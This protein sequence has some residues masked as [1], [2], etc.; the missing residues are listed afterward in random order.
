MKN[1]FQMP[2]IWKKVNIIKEVIRLN[3]VFKIHF[4]CSVHPNYAEVLNVIC[5]RKPLS[6]FNIL[7]RQNLNRFI[8][9]QFYALTNLIT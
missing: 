7:F 4:I 1:L 9:N 6:F 2:I 3:G 8:E 5:V